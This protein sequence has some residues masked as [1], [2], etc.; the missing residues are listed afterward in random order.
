MTRLN[1]VSEFKSTSAPTHD[2]LASTIS[3]VANSLTPLLELDVMTHL[4]KTKHDP[5]IC[6]AASLPQT[7][8]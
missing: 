3:N 5:S 2:A 4:F 7:K 1:Q 6:S 8:L